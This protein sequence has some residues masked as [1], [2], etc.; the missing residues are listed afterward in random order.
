[1]R[2]VR[3]TSGVPHNAVRCGSILRSK[4]DSVQFEMNTGDSHIVGSIRRNKYI[5]ARDHGAGGRGCQ[6]HSRFHGVATGTA[7]GVKREN[8]VCRLLLEKKK[9][10][11]NNSI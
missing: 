2:A 4:V 1:M 5:S 8:L 7:C 6:Y 10:L 3:G 11:S 9:K